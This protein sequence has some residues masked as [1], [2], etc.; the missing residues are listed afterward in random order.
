M[1]TKLNIKVVADRANVAASTVSRVINNSG[2][3]SKETREKVMAV[4]KELGY[5]QNKLASTLRN[6]SSS[7][8]GLIVPDISNEFYSILAKAIEHVLQKEHFSLFLC[9]T[10]E[11]EKKEAPLSGASFAI[12]APLPALLL[13]ARL[14]DH[15]AADE[16]LA[17]DPRGRV[18]GDDLVEHG[19]RNLVADLVGMPFGDGFRGKEVPAF[20]VHG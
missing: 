7:F 4:V 16:G 5:R 13:R 6:Q 14:L 11:D 9:N 3:V 15:A 1:N 18:L 8:I 10:E 20:R 12:S 19:V 17:R 2:Y